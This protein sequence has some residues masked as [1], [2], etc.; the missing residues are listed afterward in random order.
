MNTSGSDEI[1]LKAVKDLVI[2]V[3]IFFVNIIKAI[4][5][6]FKRHMLLI[7]ICA[8]VGAALG[9]VFSLIRP[10]K[11]SLKMVVRH[12]ELTKKTFAEAIDQLNNLAISKSYD[13]LAKELS[14]N[15]TDASKIVL[16]EGRNLRDE[17]LLEDTSNSKDLPFMIVAKVLNNAI[18][19]KLQAG[20]LHH[21]N[22]NDYLRDIKESKRKIYEEK[23]AFIEREL[24]KLDSL[25]SVYNNYLGVS[26]NNAMFYNNAFNPS[27]IYQRSNEYH[28]QKE[29]IQSWLSDD[30]HPLR[31]IEG[32]KPSQK[33][34]SASAMILVIAGGLCGLLAGIFVALFKDFEKMAKARAVG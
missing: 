27:E 1:S 8:G 33:A 17:L 29:S 4:L 5:Q 30:Y 11:Y 26:K 31:I 23:L 2:N 34:S 24:V 7:L 14:M 20:L 22:Y 25:K 3:I 12:N 16:L 15:K 32:F 19:S 21:F 18:A 9:Y 6:F 13:L 28:Y 10:P